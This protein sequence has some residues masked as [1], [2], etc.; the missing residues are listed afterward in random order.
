MFSSMAQSSTAAH[1]APDWEMKA[2]WPLLG[3][4]PAKLMLS[5]RP[6][7]MTPRQLGP[8]MRMS[9][10]RF[11]AAWIS[12][13]S[14][15]PAGPVSRNPAETMTTPGMPASPHS[16]TRPGTWAAGAQITATSTRARQLPQAPRSRECP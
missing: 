3:M 6:G 15:S 4:A 10:K 5:W 9:P 2:I 1:S 7:T 16:R 12:F 13:S 8:R 14:A 11:A